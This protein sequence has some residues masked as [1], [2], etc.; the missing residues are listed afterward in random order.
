M[1][2]VLEYS[3][4]ELSFDDSLE[5]EAAAFVPITMKAKNSMPLVIYGIPCIALDA[6][7]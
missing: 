4:D 5:I 7:K 6:V 1:E 2:N 3:S